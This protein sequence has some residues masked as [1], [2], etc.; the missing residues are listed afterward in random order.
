[1]DELTYHDLTIELTRIIQRLELENVDLTVNDITMVR[2]AKY[3]LGY[4]CPV[5][6]EEGT[7]EMV[8]R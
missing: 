3:L 2:K 5:S 6:V 1:M 4:S 7:G 8:S